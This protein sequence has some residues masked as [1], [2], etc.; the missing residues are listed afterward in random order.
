[1]IL[2]YSKNKFRKF[3]EV[4]I[5]MEK[6]YIQKMEINQLIRVEVD[7]QHLKNWSILTH[8]LLMHQNADLRVM[9]AQDIALDVL[10]M[11]LNEVNFRI[12][13]Y[14]GILVVYEAIC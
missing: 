5:L 1:M 14:Q 12:F 2:N 13:F 9:L 11:L 4:N 6:N 8:R 10:L 3:L 7:Y